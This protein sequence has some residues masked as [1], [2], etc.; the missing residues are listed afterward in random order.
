MRPRD[1]G[2]RHVL[3]VLRSHV[4]GTAPPPPPDD[5]D[6]VEAAEEHGVLPVVAALHAA[7]GHRLPPAAELAPAHA[8]ARRLQAASGLRRVGAALSEADVPWLVFKGPALAEQ[9]YPDDVPRPFSDLDVLVPP[10]QFERAVAALV[11]TGAQERDEPW[12]EKITIGHSEV[13]LD[14]PGGLHLDLHWDVVATGRWREHV[15]LPAGDLLT[16]SVPRTLAGVDCRVLAPLDATVQL[17]VHGCLS[18]ADRLRWLLD[19]RHLVRALAPSPSELAA[20]A[21]ATGTTVPLWLV[22]ERAERHLDP[23][24]ARWRRELSP[25]RAW[26][27]AGT[28]WSRLF[29]PGAGS[30]TRLTGTGLYLRAASGLAPALRGAARSAAGRVPGRSRS[31]ASNPSAPASRAEYYAFVRQAPS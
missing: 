28:V 22:L 17:A 19:Q 14:L 26:Q 30:D 29:P 12:R 20:H 15:R 24:L 13:S 6:W 7:A 25:P 3:A 23:G 5:E 18:G 9:V 4:D 31:G 8:Y 21:A 11:A 2:T 1:P 27:V 16:R 10:G